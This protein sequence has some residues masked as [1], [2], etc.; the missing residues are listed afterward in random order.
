MEGHGEEESIKD[1]QVVS[2]SQVGCRERA[3]LGEGVGL[4]SQMHL[5]SM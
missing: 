1:T 3:D 5:K 2:C 4:G